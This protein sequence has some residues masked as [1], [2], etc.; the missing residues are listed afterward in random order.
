MRWKEEKENY[1]KQEQGTKNMYKKKKKRRKDKVG[2]N[3]IKT[4]AK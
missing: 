4:R 2:K 1:R 3:L